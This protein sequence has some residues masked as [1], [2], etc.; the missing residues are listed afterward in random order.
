[1]GAN[2]NGYRVTVDYSPFRKW[3]ATYT[4]SGTHWLARHCDFETALKAA[5]AYYDRG[6]LGAEVI[7]RCETDEQAE[8]CK[9]R[10]FVPQSA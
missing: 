5:V 3:A 8:A 9:A 2:Y 1:M 4:W 7:V 6:D 10:G